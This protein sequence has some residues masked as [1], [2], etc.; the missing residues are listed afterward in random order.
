MPKLT[1]PHSQNYSEPCSIACNNWAEEFPY[2]PKGEFRMRHDDHTLHIRF[3]VQEQYTKA[4]ITQD[5]GK[6][7][8][9]SAVEFFISFDDT[10]YYNFEFT[11][12]GK[13]LL[14]F[15]KE[16]PSPTPATTEILETIKRTSS[17][18]PMNFP[19]KIG[20]N[21]WTLEVAIPRTAFFKHSFATLNGID[22]RANVYKC[23]DDLTKPHFLSWAPITV[24]QPNFHL[25]AYF[26]DIRF[27]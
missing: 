11:C 5:N 27:Q 20:D 12:I 16:K 3:D 6:V 7:W 21:R 9:D 15:R 4:E 8:T 17:L 22:A 24:A 10:G 14:A 1:I 13:M 26:G 18:G 19:E 23:G 2:A 25:P